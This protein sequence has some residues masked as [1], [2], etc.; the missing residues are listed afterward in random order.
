MKKYTV[1]Y[2]NA[3]VTYTAEKIE[4][5]AHGLGHYKVLDEG[6]RDGDYLSCAV[7]LFCETHF[8]FAGAAHLDSCDAE[9]RGDRT[10]AYQYQPNGTFAGWIN[11]I[12]EE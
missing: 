7:T 4:S 3:K 2:K 1:D 9:T 10:R 8:M 5:V 12:V 11:A 6:A